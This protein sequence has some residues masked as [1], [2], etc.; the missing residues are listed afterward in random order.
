MGEACIV[1]RRGENHDL[2]SKSMK[3]GNQ[4]PKPEAAETTTKAKPSQQTRPRTRLGL[5]RESL[6]TSD[7]RRR[8][9][10]LYALRQLERPPFDEVAPLLTKGK[11][12]IGVRTVLLDAARDAPKPG[13]LPPVVSQRSTDVADCSQIPRIERDDHVLETVWPYEAHRPGRLP[14]VTDEGAHLM[15]RKAAATTYG[16]TVHLVHHDP[17]DQETMPSETR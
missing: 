11:V 13:P 4:K 6:S 5:G 17:K 8:A 2:K 16:G 3:T 12:T 1:V 10:E 14:T 7:G 15:G 9:G